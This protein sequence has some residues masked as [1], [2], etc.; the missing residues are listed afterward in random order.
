MLQTTS[1]LGVDLCA[2]CANAGYHCEFAGGGLPL[3]KYM[4]AKFEE[5]VSKQDK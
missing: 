4:Y 3:P 2:A 1:I 5:L